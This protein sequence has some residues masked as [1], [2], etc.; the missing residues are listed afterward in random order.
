MAEI[1]SILVYLSLEMPK[2]VKIPK[3]SRIDFLISKELL[4]WSYLQL[5][6]NDPQ[7]N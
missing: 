2:K 1:W 6:K 5:K 3:W 7:H 4:I